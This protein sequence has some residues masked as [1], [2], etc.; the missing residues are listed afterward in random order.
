M[1]DRNKDSKVSWW[2][3]LPQYINDYRIF[4]RIFIILYGWMTYST[5]NWFFALED[6]SHAQSNIVIAVVSA[7]AVWF[8]LYVNS[9]KE[10][11]K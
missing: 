8:G 10:N 5:F 3:L 4:P 2:E 7:G 11:D 1:T 6:P 9:G